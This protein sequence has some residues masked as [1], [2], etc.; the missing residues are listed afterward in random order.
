MVPRGGRADDEA[1]SLDGSLPDR[2][3]RDVGARSL[4]VAPVGR[5]AQVMNRK[6]QLTHRE[7]PRRSG[8]AGLDAKTREFVAFLAHELKSP[9][10]AIT[11]WVEILKTTPPGSDRFQRAIAA[12]E[13]SISAQALLLESLGTIS[14][15]VY[16]AVGVDLRPLDAAVLIAEAVESLEAE[17]ESNQLVLAFGP[18]GSD[19][20]ILGDAARLRQALRNLFDNAIKFTPAGGRIEIATSR[21]DSEAEI[22]VADSGRGIALAETVRIFERFYHLEERNA[23]QGV[24]QVLQMGLGLHVVKTIVEAHGGTVS[25]NSDGPGRGATFTIRLP[26]VRT[27]EVETE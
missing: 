12:I 21:S 3:G 20:P 5:T 1:V 25:A 16:G 10:H 14:G 23:G 11:C 9:L 19:L 8:E 27:L 2:C 17:V 13:R 18:C 24:T 15:L 26:L 22:H 7:A 4:L 6:L